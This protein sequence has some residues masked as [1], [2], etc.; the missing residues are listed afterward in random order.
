MCSQNT[1]GKCGTHVAQKLPLELHIHLEEAQLRTSADSAASLLT[2]H[3][4]NCLT[5]SLDEKR[6]FVS[7]SACDRKGF[8]G[9]F[10]E[11][12][13]QPHDLIYDFWKHANEDFSI[14]KKKKKESDISGH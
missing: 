8:M 9:S 13:T 14:R 1:G 3:T 11:G 6:R 12:K 10:S 2:S 4:F 5:C 7:S